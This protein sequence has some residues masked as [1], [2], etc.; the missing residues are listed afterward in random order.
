MNEDLGADA[1]RWFR[2]MSRYHAARD[3]SAFLS[4]VGRFAESAFCTSFFRCRWRNFVVA[5]N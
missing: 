1:A 5:Q 3:R 4:G 2:L